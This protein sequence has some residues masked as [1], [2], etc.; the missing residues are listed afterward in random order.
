MKSKIGVENYVTFGSLPLGQEFYVA[1]LGRICLAIKCQQNNSSVVAL[2]MEGKDKG[3]C[4]YEY[5]ET[6]VLI[7]G[8]YD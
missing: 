8:E 1:H 3:N 4:V 5:S 7:G 2:I 6:K